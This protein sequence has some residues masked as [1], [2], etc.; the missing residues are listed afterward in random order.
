MRPRSG[1]I[2]YWISVVLRPVTV[3]CLLGVSWSRKNR[4]RISANFIFQYKI[5]NARRIAFFSNQIVNLAIHK[6]FG[7]AIQRQVEK[8]RRHKQDR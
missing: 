4:V 7:V 8:A 3:S 5:H 2:D 1:N 6:S